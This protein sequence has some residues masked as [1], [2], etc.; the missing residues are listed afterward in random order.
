MTGTLQIKNGKYYCVLD[1]RDEK[2][3]RKLKWISTG[4]EEKGNKRKATEMLNK[5]I[6][7]YEQKEPQT[8]TIEGT[9][10]RDILFTDYMKNW[11]ERKKGKV[12]Q[13]S[14][15]VYSIAIHKHLIPYF[16]SLHLTLREIKP[17]H[18]VDYY[19][20]KFRSGRRDGKGGF[21]LN[22]L[23]MHRLILKNI[24]NQA[25]LEELIDRNPAFKVPIPKKEPTEFK[26]KFL[27]EEEANR[28][29]QIFSGH[30]LQPIIYLTLC[31]GL[32]RGEVIGLKWSAI[33]FKNNK[34]KIN[35]IITQNISIEAKD[36]TKTSSSNREYALLP[37]IKELLLKIKSEQNS[38][39]KLFKK[40]YK[41]TDYVFTWQDG[42]PYQPN[43]VT[44][45]FKKV[46]AKN[47]FPKMRFHDLRHSCA[48]ILYDKNWQLKD[49]QTWL[50]HAN[51]ETTGNIYTHI[52][53]SRKELL[54]KD[55]E[56]TF[57]FTL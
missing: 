23:K 56:N 9:S 39:K 42:R 2:G 28:L 53:K 48:S 15:D 47:N 21:S 27:N 35:H 6:V 17:K 52:S 57:S 49:I 40:E 11:M 45:E 19:D 4:L 1:Y 26:A 33:D 50:G 44:K 51:I 43:Y 37:E 31:Y 7:E 54:A 10:Q 5:I 14:L 12:E 13:S 30:H 38:Y 46:L 29:L 24:L 16:D 55:L 25:Y 36:R 18:I 32:R 41:K 8:K 3:A 20:T 22:S 34:L